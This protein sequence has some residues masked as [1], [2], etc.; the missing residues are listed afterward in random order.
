MAACTVVNVNAAI[1]LENTKN[2]K[3]YA[4]S[5]KKRLAFLF[6]FH[7]LIILLFLPYEYRF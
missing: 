4:V 7:V 2:R 5:E 3:I 1:L 6:R